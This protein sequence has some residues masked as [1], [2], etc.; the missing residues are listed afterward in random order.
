MHMI[1]YACEICKSSSWKQQELKNNYAQGIL[2][3]KRNCYQCVI[4]RNNTLN[5]AYV[6]AFKSSNHQFGSFL[7]FTA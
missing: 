7:P 2:L 6:Y 4:A 3:R 1:T 5:Y